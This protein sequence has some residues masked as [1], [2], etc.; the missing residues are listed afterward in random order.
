MNVLGRL[1]GGRGLWQVRSDQVDSFYT[2]FHPS[3]PETAP[4]N[5]VHCFP[6]NDT[7]GSSTSVKM[8]SEAV[9]EFRLMLETLREGPD[10]ENQPFTYEEVFEWALLMLSQQQICTCRL[11][12]MVQAAVGAISAQYT[13][14]NDQWAI[15]KQ[16]L[17]GVLTMEVVI[18]HMVH[19]GQIIS[20]QIER[21]VY[22]AVSLVAPW[23]SG[24]YETKNSKPIL[25]KLARKS[26]AWVMRSSRW[27]PSLTVRAE[28]LRFVSMCELED[29]IDEELSHQAT[30]GL[31]QNVL[32]LTVVHL[33]PKGRIGLLWS[34]RKILHHFCG[35]IGVILQRCHQSILHFT[36]GG[37]E[38]AVAR[39]VLLMGQAAKRVLRLRRSGNLTSVTTADE[40]MNILS[41]LRILVAWPPNMKLFD[42][43]GMCRIAAA[44]IAQTCHCIM[45]SPAARVTEVDFVNL[46]IGINDLF[47]ALCSFPLQ[48]AVLVELQCYHGCCLSLV[49]A[50][51]KVFKIFP[52]FIPEPREMMKPNAPARFLDALTGRL[53]D[54]PV[55]HMNTGVVMDQATFLTSLLGTPIDPETGDMV[56]DMSY[57]LMTDLY[58]E[59]QVWR[60]QQQEQQPS[61]DE[62]GS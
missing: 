30:Y 57:E 17:V 42:E 8:E 45:K 21:L 58:E 53:M 5:P 1:G 22:L 9:M 13:G 61:E 35:S 60:Q 19:R 51:L 37:N 43:P 40:F 44:A 38:R 15:E 46:L 26:I 3:L 6:D 52:H 54:T 20:G 18:R 28:L 62:R 14:D 48:G 11:F 24:L 56:H 39:L 36:V 59:I 47:K 29:L 27:C 41:I 12:E 7:Q 50:K 34:I 16:A 25:T 10:A 4:A 33:L 31:L 32:S 55:K 2:Q 49:A 23:R